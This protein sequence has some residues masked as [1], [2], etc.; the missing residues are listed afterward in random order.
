MGIGTGI[1][2]YVIIWWLVLF[3]VLPWGNRPV[4]VPEQGHE[5]SAPAR[6][7]LWLKFAVTTLIATIVWAGVYLA[8]DAG[9]VSLRYSAAP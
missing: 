4:E 2:A 3:T 6:P 1:V 5:T 9:V 7:R 8:I